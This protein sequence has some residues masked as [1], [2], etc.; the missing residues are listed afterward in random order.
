LKYFLFFECFGSCDAGLA[1]KISAQFNLFGACILNL[2]QEH[3]QK[4]IPDIDSGAIVGCFAM[5]G[6][7]V[8]LI[9][10]KK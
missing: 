2:G 7:F 6:L 3:H 10:L 9:F 8:K 1:M 4:Y 5:T